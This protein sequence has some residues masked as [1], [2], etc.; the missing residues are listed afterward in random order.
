MPFFASSSTGPHIVKP[1]S[2]S[3]SS[4][5]ALRPNGLVAASSSSHSSLAQQQ[6]RSATSAAQPSATPT[7]YAPLVLVLRDFA[8]R[9]QRRPSRADVEQALRARY[10]AMGG[11]LK[12]YALEA[13]LEGVIRLGKGETPGAGWV[14]LV[15]EAAEQAVGQGEQGK[16]DVKVDEGAGGK[17]AGA[18]SARAV[19]CRGAALTLLCLQSPRL[20]R[21][22]RL[23][24]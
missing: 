9:G 5:V 13:A 4:T 20:R 24:S 6:Q 19:S 10:P 8:S 2:A 23:L 11:Y 1:P 15:E 16:E 12:R 14:E 22:R 3:Y 7:P 18:S 21:R 17:G